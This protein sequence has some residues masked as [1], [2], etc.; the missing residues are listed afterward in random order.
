MQP[1]NVTQILQAINEG[2]KFRTEELLPLV[3][4][5]LKKLAQQKMRLESAEHTLQPTALVHEAFVRLVTQ[6]NSQAWDHRGH[7]Y[8]AAAEAMRRIL[9]ES[10]RR[11][12]SL[13]RGGNFKRI[14]LD[15]AENASDDQSDSELVALSEALD[16]FEAV[17]PEAAQIVK[18]RYFT[19][20][21]I[22]E[23]AEMLKVSPRTAKR[24]WAYARAWLQREL[25]NTSS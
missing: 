19:G 6:G 25:T 1:A 7:F 21:T 11:K 8:M 17:D 22:D 24:H 9:I 23:V 10:A 12:S 15:E 20:L 2:Q 4:D 3:Y 14:S 16:R 18:L 5:E 13:K